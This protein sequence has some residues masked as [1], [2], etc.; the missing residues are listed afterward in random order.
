ME[1]HDASLGIHANLLHGG[2]IHKPALEMF[3]SPTSHLPSRGSLWVG[4]SGHVTSPCVG[5]AKSCNKALIDLDASR[6]VKVSAFFV[7]AELGLTAAKK[8]PD[9]FRFVFARYCSW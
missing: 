3:K 2:A 5:Y 8:R 6:C 4:T 9:S 1:P 7:E